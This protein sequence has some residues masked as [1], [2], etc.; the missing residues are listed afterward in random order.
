MHPPAMPARWNVSEP[1]LIAETFSSRIW[2]VRQADG[3]PAIVKALKDF[4]DVEDEWRGVHL[5]SWRRGEGLVRLF[6]SEDKMMLIEYAGERHLRAVLDDASDT[7][8]TEISAEVMARLH[9]PSRHPVPS[10]LQP[11]RDRFVSLFDKAKADR[12]TGLESSY[13]DAAEIA[14]RLLSDPLD[15]IPL[16]GDIHHDNIIQ[17]PRGWLAIDAKGIAGRPGLR[18][19][20]HVLQPA[21]PVVH[22]YGAYRDDGNDLL[23]LD[24]SGSA[25]FA[26]SCHRL[27]LPVGFMAQPGQERSRRGT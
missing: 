26:R 14:E 10:D 22:R 5:L 24:E 16:H 19:C 6:D 25:P 23:A 13:V 3:T 2:K 1:V 18:R 20:Q 11:L 27:W 12:N 7:A 15:V 4:D 17:S 9:S 21:G 8:A